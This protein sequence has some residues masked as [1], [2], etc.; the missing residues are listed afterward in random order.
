MKRL[1][2]LAIEALHYRRAMIDAEIQAIQDADKPPQE[3]PSVAPEPRRR[4]K[5]KKKTRTYTPEQREAVRLRMT[6]YWAKKK[7]AAR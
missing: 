6:R 2:E 3:A 5:T 4:R 7:R 1:T